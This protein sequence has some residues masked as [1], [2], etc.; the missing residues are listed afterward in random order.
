MSRD[1][2][3]EMVRK[4]DHVKPQHDL[5][6]WLKYV[7]MT[8]SE[9]DSIADSF[10]DPRVWWIENGEWVKDNIWGGKSSYGP[11]HLPEKDWLKYLRNA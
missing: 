4:Y 1:Q 3:I 7:D 11:V 8:E 6:R 10:R 9:F 2:G 5:R